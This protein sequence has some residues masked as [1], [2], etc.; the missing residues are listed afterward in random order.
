MTRY[1]LDFPAREWLM[2][3]RV[4]KRVTKRRA[5]VHAWLDAEGI[6]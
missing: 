6:L 1:R 4:W 5:A 3:L 2:F